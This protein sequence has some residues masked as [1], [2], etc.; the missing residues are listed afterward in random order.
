LIKIAPLGRK[1][2]KKKKECE[3]KAIE[4]VSDDDKE[5]DKVPYMT[6][7]MFENA[8]RGCRPSVSQSDLQ[9]YMRFQRD[10]ERRLGVP[11][12]EAHSGGD[13]GGASESGGAS[14]SGAASKNAVDLRA[15]LSKIDGDEDEIYGDE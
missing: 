12:G 13:R 3:E 8:I 11:E 7:E 6:N 10:M 2:E 1:K 5:E 4:Y 9:K 15:D 14:G